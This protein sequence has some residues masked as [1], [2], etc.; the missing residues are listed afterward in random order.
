MCRF[1]RVCW[2]AC[3]ESA[4]LWFALTACV[5]AFAIL[6]ELWRVL[7]NRTKVGWSPL[8]LLGRFDCIPVSTRTGML[9]ALQ[10]SILC[11]MYFVT[12]WY[13]IQGYRKANYRLVVPWYKMHTL[14]LMY[15]LILI[16]SHVKESRSTDVFLVTGGTVTN[17]LLV[18]GA[19]GV[20]KWADAMG[21]PQSSSAIAQ[22]ARNRMR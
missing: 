8:W 16:Y 13:L 7:T 22:M 15:Q 18:A 2:R 20:M 10:V 11:A 1:G 12:C 5:F 14:L 21:I 19:F 4:V 17:V 3:Q 9:I 6:I